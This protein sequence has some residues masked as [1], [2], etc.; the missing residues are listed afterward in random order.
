MAQQA[1][2]AC[3]CNQ[4]LRG[5]GDISKLLI[6]G[7]NFMLVVN[8]RQS[9]L[10]VEGGGTCDGWE[11]KAPHQGKDKFFGSPLPS[12]VVVLRLSS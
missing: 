10:P 12:S 9:T 2:E 7:R 11:T 3:L 1:E 4:V 8:N 6:H 5:E